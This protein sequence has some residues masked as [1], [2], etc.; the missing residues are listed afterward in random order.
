[1]QETEL[2]KRL[3][4]GDEHAFRELVHTYQDRVYNTALGLLQN[5]AD[6]EDITQEVFVKVF[7]SIGQYREEAQL[8]TWI[9]RITTTQ[10]L[11][12]L[13]KKG[14]KKR[15]GFLVNLFEKKNDIPDF[16]HPGI[17]A[18]QKENAAILFKAI[19]SLPEQQKTAFI[20]QKTEGLSQ[21][22]IADIMNASESAVESLLQRAKTN[23]RK[24]LEGLLNEQI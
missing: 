12:L 4:L 15:T 6:A 8:S 5:A 7:Q 11:D 18:E 14:R 19:R 17:A 2:I 9:Y 3:V 23:L 22:E 21:R 20:L 24:Q 13:R 10:S 16:H 1:M